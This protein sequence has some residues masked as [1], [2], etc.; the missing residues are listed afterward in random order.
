VAGVRGDVALLVSRLRH[1]LGGVEGAELAILGERHAAWR[2]D[3]L[4]ELGA[5]LA[6]TL[7][8][9]EARAVNEVVVGEAAAAEAAE[10]AKLWLATRGRGRAAEENRD[11][12]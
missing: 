12:R 11:G 3:R 5:E 7:T 9:Y 6:E 8:R 4:F 1:L 10:A 2:T